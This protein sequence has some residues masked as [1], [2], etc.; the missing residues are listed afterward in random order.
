MTH[1]LLFYH[2][3]RCAGAA[4][5]DLETVPVVLL[6][7]VTF[8]PMNPDYSNV[9]HGDA[10]V[11][12]EPICRPCEAHIAAHPEGVTWPQARM[13]AFDSAEWWK[14]MVDGLAS[15][16]PASRTAMIQAGVQVHGPVP[17][18]LGDRVR[19]LMGAAS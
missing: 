11:A 19:Q 3:A 8:S 17:D 13:Y 7:L 16:A 1:E 14:R 15:V 6:N 5:G 2:C 12:K 9:K 18:A 10:N 4:S